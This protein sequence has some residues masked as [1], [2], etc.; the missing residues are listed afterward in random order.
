[1]KIL[2]SLKLILLLI[3]CALTQ[4]ANAQDSQ[5]K[6][7][8]TITHQFESK[9]ANQLIS[10][11]VILPWG[12]NK[13]KK[14]PVLYTTSGDSRIDLLT[15]QTDWLSHVE[16]GPMPAMIIV[17]IPQIKVESS[18][19]PKFI[20]A[21]GV[22]NEQTMSLLKS[23]LI[24]YVERTYLTYNYRVLEGFSS[25]GNFVLYAFK[26]APEL[27]N[28]FIASSPALELDKSNLVSDITELKYSSEYQDRLL[29]LSLGPFSNNALLFEKITTQLNQQNF[30]TQFANYSQYNFLS[31]ASLSFTDAME[32]LFADKTP[33]VAQFANKG[34][35][36]VISYFKKLSKK[37]Q[38]TLS[39][40][41]SLIELSFYYLEVNEPQKAISTM[42]HLIKTHPENTFYLGRL[43]KI[44]NE[45]GEIKKRKNILQQGLQLAMKHKNEDAMNYFKGELDT[46]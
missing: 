34:R 10:F 36:G 46:L 14:Y 32:Y 8:K 5:K 25:N 31:V 9:A 12:Y 15:Y 4:P 13:N 35:L 23:E 44:Y 42:Q 33:N 22:A 40:N 19:H 28:G 45:L 29:Y 39:P 21:S 6:G 2:I 1:M 30:H 7:I 11:D 38:Q 43:A 16:M 26:Q 37:Y 17:Q 18:L 27:F 20:A 41:P 3:T 24:P